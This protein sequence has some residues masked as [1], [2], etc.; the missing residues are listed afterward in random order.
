[1]TTSVVMVAQYA[2]GRPTSRAIYNDPTAAIV[3]RIE[4]AT[5]SRFNR[6][7]NRLSV[8]AMRLSP[9]VDSV[10]LPCWSFIARIPRAI[11]VLQSAGM[12]KPICHWFLVC[13]LLAARIPQAA[14]T[15]VPEKLKAPAGEQLILSAHA[16]G[17]QIYVCQ[18]GAD[19][20][21]AWVFKSPQADLHDKDGATIGT[22]FVGPTWKHRD[23]SEVT[24]KVVA[25]EDSSDADS[26]PWLLLSANGHSGNG[27]LAHVTTIQR[28]HTKGGQP[29]QGG[30]DPGHLSKEAKQPY[31][32][33]YYFYA[34]AH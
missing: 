9:F 10:P 21:L 17:S 16:T 3:V 4:C 6:A 8:P 14:P 27:V 33:D 25:R 26:I 15:G 23:G 22:H 1:M 20:K 34:P 7:A 29:P 5:H 12:N 18:A 2:S 24:G 31:S 28:L 19:Q 32:A 13:F 30:C 11:R